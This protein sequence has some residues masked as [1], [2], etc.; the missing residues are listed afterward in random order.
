[1]P[2]HAL[3]CQSMLEHA[4]ALAAGVGFELEDLKTGGGSDGNF[5]AAL[6][7]DPERIS[8]T[9]NLKFETSTP[10]AHPD[11]ES[12]LRERAGGR[13]NQG[14]AEPCGTTTAQLQNG[15]WCF[16]CFLIKGRSSYINNITEMM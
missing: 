13:P 12:R 8:I 6:G 10:E 14:G 3:A 15:F 4:R 11:L 5:T 16:W 9:G 1:M 7:V 2:K